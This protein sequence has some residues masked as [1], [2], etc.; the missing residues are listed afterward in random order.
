[1]TTSLPSSIAARALVRLALLGGVVFGVIAMHGL[2][3]HG[4][5]SVWE[6]T[7]HTAASPLHLASALP[8]M[9]SVTVVA[10]DPGPGMGGGMAGLC[11]AV[12]GGGIG[13]GLLFLV[14]RRRRISRTRGSVSRGEAVAA[15]RGRD[16]DPPCLIRLSIQRC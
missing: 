11:V 5:G 10:S 8:D 13:V 15:S 9:D 2:S 1:M 4:M 12:I 14:S 7:M 6:P 16:R 3:S